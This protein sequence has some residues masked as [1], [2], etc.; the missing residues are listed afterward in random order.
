MIGRPQGAEAAPYYF[1]Y[2]NQVS[3]DDPAR[4]I[5]NQLEESPGHF[6][7]GSGKRSRCTGTRRKSGASGRR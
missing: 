6:S 3:G 1:T 5:E 7:R 4:V 2:I